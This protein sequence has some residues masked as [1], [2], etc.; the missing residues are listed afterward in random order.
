VEERR[1]RGGVLVQSSKGI[2]RH[3]LSLGRA[4]IASC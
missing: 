3:S 4:G 1:I 2:V